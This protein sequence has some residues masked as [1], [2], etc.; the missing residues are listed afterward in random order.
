MAERRAALNARSRSSCAVDQSTPRRPRSAG[1]SRPIVA[2][3]STRPSGA[4]PSAHTGARSAGASGAGG[5]VRAASTSS[6][7]GVRSSVPATMSVTYVPKPSQSAG[8]SRSRIPSSRPSARHCAQKASRSA[9]PKGRPKRPCA[10]TIA[11][12]SVAWTHA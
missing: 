12:A 2:R 8:R 1:G 11:S 10:R 9:S 5:R 7:A 4:L 6:T 3:P